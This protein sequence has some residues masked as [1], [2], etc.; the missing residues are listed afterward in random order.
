MPRWRTLTRCP[1]TDDIV[2]LLLR[3]SSSAA[4]AP[5]L[6]RAVCGHARTAL[7]R[8]FKALWA[9]MTIRTD[10]GTPFASTAI[11]GLSALSIW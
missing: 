6:Q 3:G 4:S 7:P 1:M 5:C 8:A 11:A 10:N 2:A 9:A